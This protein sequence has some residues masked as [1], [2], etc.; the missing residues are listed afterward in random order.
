MWNSE[1]ATS[2]SIGFFGGR[3]TFGPLFLICAPVLAVVLS[4]HAAT[5]LD[6]SW[7]ALIPIFQEYGFV[8][9]FRLMSP[10]WAEMFATWPIVAG[11]AAVELL[12]MKILP[13]DMVKGP[14]TATGHV[15]V[16]KQNGMFSFFASIALYAAGHYFGLY[17]AGFV[18]AQIMPLLCFLS[19]FAF[20]FCWLLYVKGRLYPSTKDHLISGNI[21]F[22]FYWGVELY[23]RIFGFDVKQFTNCRFGM[24][25]WAI[26]LLDYAMAQYYIYGFIADSMLVSVGIQLIYIAKFFWWETGYFRSIDIMHDHAGWYICWGC[27]VWV[28]T[29]YTGTGIHLVNHP[30]ELGLPLSLFFFI[31]GVVCIW[32]N[33]DADHQR[34]TFRST[35]GRQKIWGK[36]P[37]KIVASYTTIDGVEKESLLLCS[38]WW[39]ISRHFHYLPEIGAAF[40]WCIPALNLQQPLFYC[41]PFLTALLLDR[42]FRDDARCADKY[43]KHW[44]AYCE[45]V[46]YKFIPKIL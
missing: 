8:G 30:I 18:Y 45:K 1:N 39:S 24:M 29:I 14:T 46:P 41:F 28:P 11:F 27:L 12:L 43:G 17:Q 34:A 4:V 42:G 33:Y 16:Y 40:F 37:E 7:L 32:I 9:A 5:K 44:D 20:G 15:P 23:P 10:S 2:A 36:E 13:G 26:L 31:S 21:L 38:G 25:G 35:H 22:D 6:G 3:R 19:V